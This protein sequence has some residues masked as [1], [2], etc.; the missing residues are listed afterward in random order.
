MLSNVISNFS[1]SFLAG[2]W[3]RTTETRIYNCI[4]FNLAIGSLEHNSLL[5]WVSD[6]GQTGGV[7]TVMEIIEEGEKN[8][9]K[10]VSEEIVIK[11]LNALEC[12]KKCEVFED[13]DGVKFF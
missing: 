2:L 10:G 8:S 13:N 4:T 7:L 1:L 9:W 6:S 12:D 11:A 5:R 3:E